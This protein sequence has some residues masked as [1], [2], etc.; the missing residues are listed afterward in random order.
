MS[1]AIEP[2]PTTTAITQNGNKVADITADDRF[3]VPQ[4]LKTLTVASGVVD[5]DVPAWATKISLS[6]NCSSADATGGQIRASLYNSGA[7][8]N[9]GYNNVL[10]AVQSSGTTA[11]AG[12]GGSFMLSAN[13]ITNA[14]IVAGH[15][16]R[17]IKR[18]S[19]WVLDGNTYLAG[20][21]LAIYTTVGSVNCANLTKVRIWHTGSAISGT[22]DV[23][24]E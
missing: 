1:F 17:L 19:R 13:G 20:G 21:A 9:T 22:F 23:I 2:S 15:D 3:V 12:D 14:Y 11:L 16:I 4:L 8:V 6:I 5:L 7:P 18:G 10:G 24:F